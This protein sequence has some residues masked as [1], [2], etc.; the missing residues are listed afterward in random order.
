MK[1][2]RLII[3]AGAKGGSG[4]SLTT[5][6]LYDWLKQKGI[7]AMVFD[8]DPENSTL[9][10]F[11][12]GSGFID[13]RQ[14]AALDAILAPL[15]K[16]EADIVL[17][18][19]RA[20]TSEETV[21]WLKQIGIQAIRTELNTTITV[22][23]MVTHSRDTLEQLRWWTDALGASVQWLIV[24]NL[25]GDQVDEYD[26]SRMRQQIRDTLSG[27]EITLRKIPGFLIETL[28][29]NNLTLHA[30]TGSQAVTWANQKRIQALTHD[31]FQQ[32]ETIKEVLIHE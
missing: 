22:A 27:K 30:A 19:S 20:A 3:T 23:V 26:A 16:N 5:A 7:R 6:L 24:R 9:S 8:G 11:I 10:R 13:M 1:T 15:S 21:Q 2:K 17:L 28:E 32:I 31:L 12:P 29:K 25:V 18:D 4:K 14:E